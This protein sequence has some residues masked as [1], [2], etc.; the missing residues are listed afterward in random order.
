MTGSIV[1]LKALPTGPGEEKR[2]KTDPGGVS[3]FPDEVLDAY[4]NV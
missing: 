2:A 1:P 4:D 3:M